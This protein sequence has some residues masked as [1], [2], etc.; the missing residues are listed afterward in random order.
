MDKLQKKKKQVKFASNFTQ[1]SFRTTYYFMILAFIVSFISSFL[2][3]S[4]SARNI[5]WI[6]CIITG[7]AAYIYS[8]YNEAIDKYN[9]THKKA[10]GW[11]KVNN[12]R[13]MDWFITT[14]LMLATLILFLSLNTNQPINIGCLI[15]LIMLDWIMLL[16]GYLGEQKRINK[17][18]A[19]I[20]GFIPFS[21]IFWILYKNYIKGR[22]NKSNKLLFIAYF[23]LWF[24]YGVLYMFDEKVMN[25]VF[26]ILDCVAKAFVAI[27]ISSTFLLNG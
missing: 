11:D 4:K 18:L 6:E 3:K 27:G 24:S 10:L 17:L 23:I 26:N 22:T 9:L 12:L 15:C 8:Q 21:A 14:P 20:L 19:D 25:T 7:Y 13:Y 5:L 16:F 1:L 2:V